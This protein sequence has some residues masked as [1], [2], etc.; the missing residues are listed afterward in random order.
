MNY[1]TKK[2]PTMV[3]MKWLSRNREILVKFLEGTVLISSIVKGAFFFSTWDNI[4]LGLHVFTTFQYHFKAFPYYILWPND[5]NGSN[6]RKEQPSNRNFS[7]Q[8]E[9]QQSDLRKSTCGRNRRYFTGRYYSR[10]RI[11]FLQFR[12]CWTKWNNI[13]FWKQKQEWAAAYPREQTHRRKL[14]L[15]GKK[16]WDA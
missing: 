11:C 4:H 5:C 13:R 16:A 6:D 14:I 9:L 2:P 1:G 8:R 10:K 3:K 15:R 12:P 7:D